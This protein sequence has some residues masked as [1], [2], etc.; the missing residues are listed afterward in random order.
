MYRLS[1]SII[2]LSVIILVCSNEAVAVSPQS[3]DPCNQ[4]RDQRTCQLM[5]KHDSVKRTCRW[6]RVVYV[7]RATKM[8]FEREACVSVP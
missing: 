8:S 7:E 2:A 1:F 6:S 5:S 4:F 3:G